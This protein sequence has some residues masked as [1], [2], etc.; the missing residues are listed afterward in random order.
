MHSFVQITLALLN[1]LGLKFRAQEFIEGVFSLFPVKIEMTEQEAIQVQFFCNMRWL[2][3]CS[4][5][6]HVFREV[7]SNTL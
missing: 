5:K 3:R 1:G 7:V 2:V 6:C 4:N